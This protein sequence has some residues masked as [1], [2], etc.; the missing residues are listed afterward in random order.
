LLVDCRFF[1]HIY[2]SFCFSF[3]KPLSHL[4]HHEK[5]SNEFI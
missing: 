5:N 2:F 1:F 3:S 4:G